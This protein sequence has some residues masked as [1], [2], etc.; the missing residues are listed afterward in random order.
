MAHV[1]DYDV[2]HATEEAVT[3]EMVIEM[4]MRNAGAAVEAV[5]NAIRLLAGC[6]PSPHA[7]A[8]RDALITDRE[9]VP[10]EVVDRLE[11][12]VGR[13]FDRTQGDGYAQ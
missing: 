8:L 12:L 7:D 13:Y 10:A 3:V 5:A 6:G 9:A 2:W 11:H 1:T 4:L